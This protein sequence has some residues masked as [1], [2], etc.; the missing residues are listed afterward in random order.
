[1]QGSEHYPSHSGT[2][3]HRQQC[4]VPSVWKRVNCSAL[5]VPS[6]VNTTSGECCFQAM[7]FSGPLWHSLLA[8]NGLSPALLMFVF[9]VSWLH[10]LW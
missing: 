3:L 10:Y 2:E 7:R 5:A 4:C 9:D 8:F 6:C 1:M